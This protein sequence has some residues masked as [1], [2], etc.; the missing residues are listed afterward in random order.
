MWALPLLQVISHLRSQW[1][2]HELLAMLYEV[3]LRR[4]R[5]THRLLATTEHHLTQLGDERKQR[6]DSIQDPRLKKAVP[7]TSLE[8][9]DRLAQE[10]CAILGKGSAFCIDDWYMVQGCH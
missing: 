4:H 7:R 3:E 2:R 1:C 5:D 10:L 8:S 6:S 9:T